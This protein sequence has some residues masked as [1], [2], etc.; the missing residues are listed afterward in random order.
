MTAQLHTTQIVQAP[1]S[2][3]GGSESTQ[4]EVLDR[5]VELL[6]ENASEDTITGINK[7]LLKSVSYE[8]LVTAWGRML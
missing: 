4:T 3:W 7:L 1:P 2:E 6:F 8:A 5:L